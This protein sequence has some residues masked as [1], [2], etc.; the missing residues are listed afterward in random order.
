VLINHRGNLT[1]LKKKKK[2]NGEKKREKKFVQFLIGNSWFCLFV[3]FVPPH[4][5]Q[6]FS[7]PF[8]GQIL[9]YPTFGEFIIK[10]R[11]YT[12]ISK[13][14]AKFKIFPNFSLKMTQ[15]FC[16]KT[17]HYNWVLCESKVR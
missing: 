3:C 7:F 11:K 2:K 13:R 14:K 1:G 9:R 10:I 17:K 4:W 15:I 16:Q 5:N 6:G 8:S 12:Q